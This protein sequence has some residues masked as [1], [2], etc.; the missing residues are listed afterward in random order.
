MNSADYTIDS[1]AK[2]YVGIIDAK[3]SKQ[4]TGFSFVFHVS[5]PKTYY[6]IKVTIRR[7]TIKGRGT[8]K[9]YKR[10]HKMRENKWGMILLVQTGIH[11]AWFK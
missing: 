6:I 5:P 10:Y 1:I 2:S 8:T 11:R 3:P 4:V 7:R 9:S